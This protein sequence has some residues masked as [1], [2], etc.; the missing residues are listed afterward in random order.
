MIKRS[1]W[2]RSQDRRHSRGACFSVLR[3]RCDVYNSEFGALFQ[4]VLLSADAPRWRGQLRAKSG[5]A[6]CDKCPDAAPGHEQEFW[7][8]HD[9]CEHAQEFALL[10]RHISLA[11]TRPT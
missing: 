9:P 8:A 6:H 11:G 4:P 5:S 2:R 10:P 3:V 1:W 7:A